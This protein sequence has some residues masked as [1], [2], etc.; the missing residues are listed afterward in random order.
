M[1]PASDGRIGQ[2]AVHLERVSPSPQN[3]ENQPANP[4]PELRRNVCDQITVERCLGP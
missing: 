4:N 2:H 1:L 3:G